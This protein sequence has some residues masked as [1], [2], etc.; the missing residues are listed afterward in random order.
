MMKV[1][2]QKIIRIVFV[3]ILVL[4]ILSIIHKKRKDDSIEVLEDLRKGKNY[5]SKS[6]EE[7]LVSETKIALDNEPR[8]EMRLEDFEEEI[9][10]VKL[11]WKLTLI[12][13]NNKF[14]EDYNISLESIDEYRK[15]DSRAIKYLMKML[16]DMKDNG[17]TNIWVQSSYRSVEYQQKIYTNQIEQYKKQGKTEQEAI[18]LTEKIINKPG[19]SEHNLGLAVDFNYVNEEFEDTKAF[20]WLKENAENYGFILRYPKE[21]E[22]IT[23]IKYEPWH[24]RY[25]GEENAKK[26]NKLNMCLE[27]YIECIK[28]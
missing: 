16:N 14:P 27:E 13:Q 26:M 1:R 7:N 19:Y 11:D 3:L 4:I 15:F 23:K 25:V 20:K 5:T 28:K 10:N 22:D 6:V 21:K 17:I 18:V 8:Q 24:W 9:G 2:R 12:N